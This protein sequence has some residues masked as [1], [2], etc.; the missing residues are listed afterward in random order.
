MHERKRT[1]QQLGENEQQIQKEKK[2]SEADETKRESK[3]KPM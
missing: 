3:Y 1:W 2:K